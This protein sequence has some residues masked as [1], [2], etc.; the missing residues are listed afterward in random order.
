MIRYFGYGSNMDLTSLK[1]KGVAPQ[2]SRVAALSGWRL[3]FNV[4]HFFRH[5]GGVG[6]IE[7]TDNPKDQVLGMLHFCNEADLAALDRAEAYGVGYDR[8]QV[9]VQTPQGREPALAYV[10]LPAYI[11]DACLPTR[12]Y[13]NILLRGATAA[14]L[15]PDYTAGL[16]ATP[17]L[18][19]PDLPP[20][21]P[22]TDR[23][24]IN[25]RD[26]RPPLTALHGSVFDM[27]RA[28]PAHAI[29]RDWFAGKD[30][31]VFLLKRMDSSD[32]TENLRDVSRDR[33]DPGQ[34]AYLNAYLHAFAEEY[35]YICPFDYTSLPLEKRLG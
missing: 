5:E 2:A 16:R 13:M 31:T 1:A 4:E 9:L 19:P 3:R 12:R 32:G 14:G 10:G 33:L 22:V 29:A 30:V 6:N 20:F 27:T 21:R 25:H 23:P 28:R 8:V 35:D 15:D 17:V 11:N 7:R 24:A 34:R 18:D 26:L